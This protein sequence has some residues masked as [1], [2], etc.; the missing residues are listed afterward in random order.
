MRI[1]RKVFPF[2]LGAWL[3]G[4]AA[5]VS[6]Q[7]FPG[8]W[9]GD[10]YIVEFDPTSDDDDG[11]RTRW[12][13]V[14]ESDTVKRV[15]PNVL[16]SADIPGLCQSCGGSMYSRW[17]GDALY[18][19]AYAKEHGKDGTVSI[20]NTFARWQDGGWGVLASL[21][22]GVR[23]FLNFVPCDGGRFIIISNETDLYDDNRRDRSPFCRASVQ[24]GRDELKI[25]LSID[26]GQEGLRKHMSDPKCFELALFSSIVLT[27]GRATLVNCSTG[28]YWVFSTETAALVKAGSMFKGVTPEMAAAGGPLG[29]AVLCVNPEKAGTVLVS[30]QDEALFLAETED[31][32]SEAKALYAMHPDGRRDDEILAFVQRRMEEVRDRSPKIVW[33]RIHPDTGRVERLK[34]P[35]EGGASVREGWKNDVWRPM[36]DGSVRMGWDPFLLDGLREQVSKWT[37][38][39]KGE[40]VAKEA[41]GAGAGRTDR[42][43]TL[44]VGGADGETG[45]D[46]GVDKGGAPAG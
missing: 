20:R 33:H 28:L 32:Q 15:I 35:P 5:Q 18:T 22:T 19:L 42:E 17:H 44:E 29:G 46:G 6:A 24:E 27:E 4:L 23:E 1:R 36:A 8:Q 2:V 40:G 43:Q 10:E 9:V 31:V 26:H 25:D 41:E 13:F 34:E 11:A 14:D 7:G 21:R 30:A 3:L 39:P 16:E 37:D 45:K 38:S 12:G